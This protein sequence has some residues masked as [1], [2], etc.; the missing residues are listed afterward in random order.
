MININDLFNECLYYNGV[1]ERP[2]WGSALHI[3]SPVSMD[4]AEIVY[5]E[6]TGNDIHEDYAKQLEDIK[7]DLDGY[8]LGGF[9]I[10]V[11]VVNGCLR[12]TICLFAETPTSIATLNFAEREIHLREDLVK[13]LLDMRYDL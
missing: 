1:D 2:I 9:E 12:S 3:F 13:T 7:E 10:G 11:G 5:R 6:L 4:A 8:T